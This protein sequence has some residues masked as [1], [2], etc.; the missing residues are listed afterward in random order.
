MTTNT[1]PSSAPLTLVEQIKIKMRKLADEFASG[2][3]NREQFHKIYE[4]YQMQLNLATGMESGEGHVHAGETIN[5]RK[6]LTAMAKGAAIYF[7]QTG[8]FLETIGDFTPNM[9][10]LAPTLSTIIEQVKEA[11]SAEAHVVPIDKDWVLFMPGTFSTAIMVF[12]NEPVMRQ[13]AI[14]E[15]MHRDFET[16]NDAA[17]R[18]GQTEAAKLVYPFMSFVR[19]SVGRK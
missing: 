16:A 11:G 7:H 15:T 3:V 17:L 14:V 9:A 19:R 4:H 8:G 10:V 13:T 6:K 5:I 18:S 1:A 12:S 2:E